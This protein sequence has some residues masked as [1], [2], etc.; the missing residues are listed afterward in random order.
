MPRGVADLRGQSAN[1]D[2]GDRGWV[3]RFHARLS[4]H[5]C[6]F[7]LGAVPFALASSGRPARAAMHQLRLPPGEGTAPARLAGRHVSAERVACPGAAE[8][9]CCLRRTRASQSEPRAEL[10]GG[11][12]ADR[13]LGGFDRLAAPAEHDR[14]AA[15]ELVSPAGSRSGDPSRGLSGASVSTPSAFSTKRS[16]RPNGTR[17]ISASGSTG[18]LEGRRRTDTSAPAPTIIW[19]A[20]RS[21][22]FPTVT[23][24]ACCGTAA[25]STN[26]GMKRF[27]AIR[28]EPAG[29]GGGAR[30][31]RVG[32]GR[33]GA[34]R[35][36]WRH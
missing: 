3:S 22:Y 13:T 14:P 28:I 32:G 30:R 12:R 18:R 15:H 7:A 8:D 24:S 26:D 20:R 6:G 21:A 4:A 36:R 2:R 31:P 9:V 33:R 11:R 34:P 27:T 19:A 25:S 5:A 17:P 16:C 10:L 29:P 23:S 35:R 1:R